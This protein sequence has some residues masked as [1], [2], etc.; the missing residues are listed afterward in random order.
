MIA[1]FRE[2]DDGTV[3]TTQGLRRARRLVAATLLKSSH[4]EDALNPPLTG[5]RAGL[6]MA[7]TLTAAFAYLRTLFW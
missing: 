2:P 5:W 1:P 7:W 6:L 3:L 4:A